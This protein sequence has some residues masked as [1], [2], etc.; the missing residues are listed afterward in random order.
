MIGALLTRAGLLGNFLSFNFGRRK[1]DGARVVKKFREGNSGI[2]MEIHRK[3]ANY[4]SIFIV[5]GEVALK[6][7]MT[8]RIVGILL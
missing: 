4:I 2:K 5:G 3:R 7:S 8:M 1:E 6:F